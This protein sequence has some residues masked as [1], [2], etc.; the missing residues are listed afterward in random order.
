MA[1]DNVGNRESAPE[2][3][4]AEAT[5]LDQWF[6]G[7]AGDDTFEF[8]AG[9]TNDTWLVRLNDVTQ[10]ID[11]RAIGIHFDGLGG[12]DSVSFTGTEEV[13]VADLY[14]TQGSLVGDTY[15]AAATNVE[16]IHVDGV[17][18]LDVVSFYDSA[19]DDAILVTVG[20]TNFTGTG[21]EL[22][23]SNF[24]IVHAYAKNGGVDTASPLRFCRQ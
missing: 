11:S 16:A 10:A 7:T 3:A 4:D 12:S 19:G 24:P 14:P 2:T 1:I 21:F 5:F 18:G 6:T 17:S 15:S 13:D 23:A 9:T 22:T 8:V 20:E